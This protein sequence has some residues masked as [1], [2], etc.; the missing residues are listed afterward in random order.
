[1]VGLIKHGSCGQRKCSSNH[2]T[3]VRQVHQSNRGSNKEETQNLKVQ[4][5]ALQGHS[6]LRKVVQPT[7]RRKACRVEFGRENEYT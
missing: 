6:A 4:T 2:A 7:T 3:Q 5:K 1:V